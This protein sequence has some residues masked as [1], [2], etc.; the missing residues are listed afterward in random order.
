[1]THTS[2]EEMVAA[3][4][5]PGADIVDS[6]SPMSASM[7]HMAVGISGESGELLDAIKKHVIYNKPLDRENV[8]EEIG[9][10]LFYIEGLMQDVGI[11]KDEIIKHNMEKLT[12]RYG[13]KYSD[14]AAQERADKV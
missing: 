12:V 4:K 5:K 8:V 14:K 9:D 7:L 2:F 13:K 6:M 11:T 1:M 10:L 3:L